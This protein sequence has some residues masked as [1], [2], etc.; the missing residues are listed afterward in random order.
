MNVFYIRRYLLVV[1]VFLG[2][3]AACSK[4]DS[5]YEKFLSGGS[6]IYPGRADSLR[7][8]SGHNRIKL[9]WLLTSDPSIVM[10]KVFWNDGADSVEIPVTR[11]QGVDTVSVVIDSLDEGYYNFEIYTYDKNGHSSVQ[12]DTIGQVYGDTYQQSLLNRVIKNAYWNHDSAFIFWYS[13]NTGAV[14]SNL[15]YTDRNGHAYEINI[16]SSDTLTVLPAFR[17]HDGFRFRTGYMPDSLAIDTFYTAYASRS[18]DDTLAIVLPDF[19]A[20]EGTYQLMSKL[21]GLVLSVKDASTSNNGTII[22]ESFSGAT[23]QLWKFV[24]APTA[25]YYQIDNLNSGLAMSVKGAST[26]DGVE[27]LQYKFGS[28]KNDQWQLEEAADGYYK[29]VNLKS[30]KVMEIAGNS[31]ASG[32]GLQQNTWNGGDNQ[33]FSLLWNM[34]FQK[35]IA[36]KSSDGS[37]GRIANVLDG[38]PTT[39][40]QPSSGDRTDDQLIWVTIDLGQ[41]QTFDALD[42]NWTHGNT[43]IDSYTVYYSDDNASWQTAFQSTSG[44]T[45][46]EN[47]AF[48]APVSGRYVKLQLHFGVDG[49]VNI[50]EIGVFYVP[51]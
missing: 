1:A 26:S 49:N 11:S 51:R 30:G 35:S 38:D 6:I 42:Q 44:P 4:M 36:A 5:T 24:E 19:P 7:L 18:I 45:A 14:V 27:I 3:L 28:G 22:Q 21:S 8:F 41:S 25:G 50:A 20:Q 43:N 23:N 13:T 46:G 34:A 17:L 15:T 37:K 33:L 47:R 29:L 16:P 9:S 39:F 10:N 32:A 12:A 31:T 48:F 2:G 40:W